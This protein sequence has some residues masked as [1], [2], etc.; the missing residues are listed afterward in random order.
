MNRY[1]ASTK[2]LKAA[3][4]TLKGDILKDRI[5]KAMKVGAKRRRVDRK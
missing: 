4:G 5:H 1:A 3:W 2:T